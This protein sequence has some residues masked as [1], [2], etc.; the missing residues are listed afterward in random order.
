MVS[1]YPALLCASGLQELSVYLGKA[2][3]HTLLEDGPVV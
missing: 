1:I 3:V 2:D